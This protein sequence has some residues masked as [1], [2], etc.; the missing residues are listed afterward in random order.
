V[1]VEG[2]DQV[3]ALLVDL[4][5]AVDITE[6]VVQVQQAK[7]ILVEMAA[8]NLIHIAVVAAAVLVL[9]VEHLEVQMLEA[10]AALEKI[11]SQHGQLQHLVVFLDI[12]QVVLE[13]AEFQARPTQDLVVVGHLMILLEEAVD[14]ALLF[15]VILAYSADQEVQL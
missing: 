5:A 6:P 1:V 12:T 3:T 15:F 13:V 2:L 11:Q 9:L 8:L 7:A 10:L 14:Q 4:V